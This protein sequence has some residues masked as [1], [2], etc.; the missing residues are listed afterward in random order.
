[1]IGYSLTMY[2]LW[3]SRQSHS[4]FYRP[5]VNIHVIAMHIFRSSIGPR[6]TLQTL[7]IYLRAEYGIARVGNVRITGLYAIHEFDRMVLSQLWN[8]IMSRSFGFLKKILFVKPSVCLYL[9]L[10][11]I[12]T[13]P[14]GN[15][16]QH[17][18]ILMVEKKGVS[19]GLSKVDRSYSI[20]W[21]PHLL[22]RDNGEQWRG[23]FYAWYYTRSLA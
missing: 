6:P 13:E 12:Y 15:I 19:W 3:M 23:G 16:S 7:G 21:N 8:A 14:M 1:M 18:W 10:L 20:R 2:T 22:S 11:F 4:K 5:A 17:F 9:I